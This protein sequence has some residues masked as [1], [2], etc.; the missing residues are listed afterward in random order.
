MDDFSVLLQGFA[1]SPPFDQDSPGD[2]YFESTDGTRF[3]VLR[4]ILVTSSPYFEKLLSDLST[5]SS[6]DL[7]TLK[8]DETPRILHALLIVLYPVHTTD[9]LD[10]SLLLELA[11]RQEKYLIPETAMLLAASKVLGF[12]ARSSVASK[13]P[14]ELYAAA[15]RFGFLKE[16][17]YFSRYTHSMDL[18]DETVVE[19][20]VRSSGRFKA[21]IALVELRQQRE[22]ALDGIIEA[23]EPRKHI[24]SSHLGSDQM[25]FDVVSMIKTAARNALQVPFPVCEEAISFL[26]LQGPSEERT[27]TWCSSCYKSVDRTR[28]TTQLQKAI[29][30]YPQM[31]ST[32][33]EINVWS[34]W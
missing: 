1:V 5:S 32:V 25:F 33:P 7:P 18:M 11:D 22:R 27:V 21:Y 24:C 20:L 2:C 23:M 16:T 30:K 28:L 10:A 19:T 14:M 15:W 26:G 12:S 6:P 9:F 31:T 8:I 34:N 29:G 3:K 17:Q 4:H 13:H